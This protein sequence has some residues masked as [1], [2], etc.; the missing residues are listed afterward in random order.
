[1]F[2]P[3]LSWYSDRLWFSVGFYVRMWLKKFV[4]HRTH[5]APGDVQASEVNVPRRTLV[6]W[7]IVVPEKDPAKTSLSLGAFPYVCPEP[8]LVK[9]SVLV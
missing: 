6:L 7:H 8:V 9:R 4:L 5:R 3:S 2:V 1:M